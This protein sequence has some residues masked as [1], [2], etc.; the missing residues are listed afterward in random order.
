MKQLYN[1]A[2][3]VISAKSLTC[4]AAFVTASVSGHQL[5]F[6]QNA[7]TS[8][9][10]NL[11][12][13][14]VT[15]TKFPKKL[16]EIGK[17][18]RVI[19]AADLAR[20]QGKTLYELLNEQAGIT[21]IGAGS[22]PGKDKSLS[23]RGAGSGYTLVLL[24]GVPLTDPSGT[25]NSFDLRL[26]NLDEIERIEILKGGQS[27]LYGSDAVAGVINLITKKSGKNPFN[28]GAT[29]SAGSLGSKRINLNAN[30]SITKDLSY[31]T[32]YSHF[33]TDGIAEAVDNGSDA[34][35]HGHFHRNG[36][37]QNA[38]LAKL[39]YNPN[40][41][42]SITPYFRLTANHGTTPADAFMDGA[43]T[44]KLRT[45]SAGLNSSF[46]IPGAGTI[47]VTDLYTYT[48]RFYNTEY[49]PYGYTGRFNQAEVYYTQSLGS[50]MQLIAG[51]SQ[52]HQG[53]LDSVS[54]TRQAEVNII[55]PYVSFFLKN[56][57]GFNLDL[58]GRLTHHS[59]FGNNYT[60]NINPSYSP[61]SA[62]KVFINASS[63]FKA[64]T[65]YELYAGYYG[66]IK[67]KPEKSVSYEGG[68]T[69]FPGKEF[70][71]DAVVYQRTINN[72]ITYYNNQYN[73]LDKQNNRGIEIEPNWKPAKG[74]TIKAFYALV[75]GKVTTKNGAGKDTTYDNIIRIPRNS[76]GLFAGYQVT[77]NLY[78]SLNYRSYQHRT[79]QDFSVYPGIALVNLK[80]Y[81]QL[82]GYAEYTLLNKKLK[83]F[84]QLFNILNEKFTEVYG[85]S[86]LRF[87]TEIGLHYSL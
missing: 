18:I 51:L 82:D 20:S 87:H 54:K 44:Y 65:L 58:G 55:S 7:D 53:T 35:N 43:Y 5:A 28:A 56:L 42:I 78:L 16:S 11:S 37:S 24:D 74:L 26:I 79:D 69:L 21:V 67:L 75:L 3:K 27:T 77:S 86:T 19:S 1:P 48:Q 73:N 85:Y 4:I 29:V 14:V 31:Y 59:T 66:N 34:A 46:I 60:W 62:L 63:A 71:L 36:Y 38:L 6:A 25:D 32:S 15:A 81:S 49:G 22:N 12:E 83:V 13:V 23:L 61:C 57:S 40:T 45:M 80:G 76:Y 72:E 30:G 2:G 8:S 52:Q 17:V 64:P 39:I 68:F 70:N 84:A 41:A 50:H 9:R 33:Q 10:K 47:N